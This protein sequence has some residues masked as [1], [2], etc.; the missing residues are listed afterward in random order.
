MGPTLGNTWLIIILPKGLK[1]N[2]IRFPFHKRQITSPC[3]YLPN[4]IK[5]IFVISVKPIIRKISKDFQSYVICFLPDSV[6]LTHAS[7]SSRPSSG[8]K[9][10]FRDDQKINISN[11]TIL[12]YHSLV[13]FLESI[14]LCTRFTA[15]WQI[16]RRSLRDIESSLT[17]SFVRHLYLLRHLTLFLMEHKLHKWVEIQRG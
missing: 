2:R 10:R 9:R 16:L 6:P 17:R 11:T 1:D 4:W 8:V 5:V 15:L 12:P 13:H 14:R 7:F 3:F